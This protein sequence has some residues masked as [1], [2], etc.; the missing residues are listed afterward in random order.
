MSG[1]L[2]ATGTFIW[3]LAAICQLHRRPFA[4]EL[5]LQQFPPPYDEHSLHDAAVALRLKSGLRVVPASE[6]GRLPA[7][8]L[9]VLEPEPAARA[10]EARVLVASEPVVSRLAVVLKCDDTRVLY[11]TEEAAQPS[12]ALLNDFGAAYAGMVLICTPEGAPPPEDDPARTGTREFGFQW[13]VPELLRHKALWRD[14]LLASAAIQLVALAVPLCTQVVIDKVI[15]HQT[16]NTL[17]VIALALGIFVVFNAGLTWIRQYLV[18]HTG[19]RVDAV[20]GT[21]AFQHLLALPLRYFERR[22]TG[23]LVARLHGVETIREF[24]SGAAVSL[25]LDLPFLVLFLAIMFWYSTMLSLITVAV[26]GVIAAMSLAIVPAVRRRLNEQF[27]LGARNTAFLTEYVSA[28]ETVKSLQLEP[29]LRE[30]FGGYLAAYLDAT[31]RTRQLSNT[32]G[33][34]ANALEQLLTFT[35]LCVGAWM[36]M[37]NT[38][39]TV[40]MLVAYQMFASRLSQPVL[41][42]VGLWQE[43]QQSAIAVKRLGDIMNAPPEPYSTVPGR[44]RTAD[45]AIEIADVA[46]RY[47]DETPFLYEHLDGRIDA[48][49]CVAIMG[50]SGTG[51]STLAKLMQGLY[52]P[53][54]GRVSVGGRDTQHLTANEL[55]QHFGVVPQETRLFSGT[56]YENL[57]IANPHAGFEHI[58]A[59]CRS[60]GIHQAIEALP[61]GYQTSIG[62]HGVGL[63]GGQ[64]QRIAIARALLKGPQILVFDEAASGLDDAT[65]EAL[66]R[67]INGLRGRVT[68]VFIAHQLPR[69]LEVDDV[70][71]LGTT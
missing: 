40:G 46:F 34:G 1:P 42:L 17:A 41:R 37:Q 49:A 21:R 5:V 51:K 7:P 36:V 44:S 20:L 54:H 47:S 4:P 61:Q 67:T 19:T 60:A 48:G 14:V 57:A 30:R 50:P 39:F 2:F 12:I 3:G 31:F 63:S 62:E 13:F 55:R 22:P 56:I 15:A 45:A 38:G 24:V 33:V 8:F 53:T 70:I 11:V 65:A 16:L 27:L 66:A 26:L 35:I 29:Q 71:T 18:L 23:V 64:R 43:F 58:V 69:A 10:E 59:A 52:S 68:I 28:M 25:I 9:A 6:L 32:Y